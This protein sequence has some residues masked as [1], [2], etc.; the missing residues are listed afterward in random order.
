MQQHMDA[1][2][3]YSN[4]GGSSHKRARSLQEEKELAAMDDGVERLSQVD[5]DGDGD[6][7]EQPHWKRQRRGESN[8]SFS[9]VPAETSDANLRNNENGPQPRWIM[10][11]FDARSVL[12]DIR[13]APHEE[14]AERE[15]SGYC[16]DGEGAYC[17]EV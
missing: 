3:G 1:L 16:F 11:G 2:H 15:A 9:N 12:Q 13:R 4:Y 5:G 14:E 10:I 17:Q 6:E 8:T 7:D